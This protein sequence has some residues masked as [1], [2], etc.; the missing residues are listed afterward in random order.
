MAIDWAGI[1][2]YVEGDKG[3]DD[4]NGSEDSADEPVRVGAGMGTSRRKGPSIH[5]GCVELE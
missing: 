2:D 5:L 3:L 4:A 1:L